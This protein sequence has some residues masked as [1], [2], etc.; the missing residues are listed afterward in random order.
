MDSEP[1]QNTNFL[2]SSLV[3]IKED[4]ALWSFTWTLLW[5]QKQNP[6]DSVRVKSYTQGLRFVHWERWRVGSLPLLSYVKLQTT[7]LLSRH[8]NCIALIREDLLQGC[9]GH[10]T[11]ASFSE[12]C[13]TPQEAG[14]KPQ[15]C[16]VTGTLEEMFKM[17]HPKM[18]LVGQSLVWFKEREV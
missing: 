8:Q 13:F 18:I 5:S 16:K 10:C 17:W 12:C 7:I 14:D 2:L 11:K 1:S 4:G 9:L 15:M 3:W 6:P